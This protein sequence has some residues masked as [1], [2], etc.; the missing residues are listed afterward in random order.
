MRL[1]THRA[2]TPPGYFQDRREISGA[3]HAPGTPYRSAK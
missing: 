3:V 2:P 1:P